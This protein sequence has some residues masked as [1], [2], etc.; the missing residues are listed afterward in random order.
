MITEYVD[1]TAAREHARAL[2]TAAEERRDLCT[3][4]GKRRLLYMDYVDYAFDEAGGFIAGYSAP[5]GQGAIHEYAYPTS[6]F[7]VLAA[8]S[9][10]TAR[11]IAH[12]MLQ[13]I[14]TSL[15]YYST[16]KSWSER[17][18]RLAHA[19]ELAKPRLRRAHLGA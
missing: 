2:N 6:E 7:A 16:R 10:T 14:Y 15:D 12:A 17:Q 4:T 9:E 8:R 18:M 19:L 1:W 13:P 5:G 3:L 11:S